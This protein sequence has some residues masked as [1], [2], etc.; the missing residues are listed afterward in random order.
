[1]EK[2]EGREAQVQDQI[3]ELTYSLEKLDQA[4]NGLDQRLVSVMRE[5]VPQPEKDPQTKLDLVPVARS[6][7]KAK[8]GV[9][10][11]TERIG[12][13]LDRLEL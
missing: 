3:T 11:I 5:E 1:M 8:I 2:L 12:D 7:E 4:V 10:R 9:S 6:I 13:I